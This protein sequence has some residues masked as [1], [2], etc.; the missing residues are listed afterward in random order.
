MN[1]V[2]DRVPLGARRRFPTTL[3]RLGV[4]N[5]VLAAALAGAGVGSYF[6]VA[7]TGT[8]PAPVRTATAERGVVTSSVSASGT[9]QAPTQVG[10]DFEASGRLTSVAVKAGQQVAKGQAL[11]TIDSTTAQQAVQQA[12]ASLA[13]AQAQYE[14]TVTGETAQQRRQDALSIAQA[15]QSLASAL[16]TVRMDGKSSAAAVAEAQRQLAVDQGQE[17]VDLYQQQKDQ[18]P[19]STADA[20]QAAVD[21]DKAQLAADTQQQQ[22]DQQTQYTYQGEQTTDN[23]QLT[24]DQAS[25]TAAQQAK[26][27]NGITTY[28]NAVN[29]DKADIANVEYLLNQI[30]K[31]LSTDGYDISLDNQ[32][33]TTDT[34]YLTALQSDTKTIRADEAKI[35]SD[36]Q[37]LQNAQVSA[38]TTASRDA[39]SVAAA[40]IGVKTARMSVAVKQAPPTA[41]ALAAAKAAVV[42]AQV[43]LSSAELTLSETT[44]RAPI[45][46]LV[47]SVNGVVGTTV[48][49][50]GSTPSATSSSSSGSS[51]SSSS[52]FVTLTDVRG[53][54]VSASFA[55]TDAAKLKVG[56]PATVT[57]DALPSKEFAAHVI[58]IAS[59]AS[60]S[61][62]NV[63]TYTVLFSL[64]QT[65]AQLKP[66]MTANVDVVVG[67]QDNVVHVPTA[68]INGSGS[69]ATVTVLRNGKQVT[70]PVVVGL[71]GDSSTA[72]L[73]GVKAGDQVV[74]PSVSIAASSSGTTGT[75]GAGTRGGGG[76]VFRFGGGFGG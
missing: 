15:K 20:A 22:N 48:A 21:A 5:A 61:S 70:V 7:G 69:G 63:V 13:S 68:A 72:I 54:L 76:A 26:D 17:K 43:A 62:S 11:G 60:T 35:G 36:R 2:T 47:A 41:A 38:S 58:S 30:Q 59:T 14:Q 1:V 46:G 29:A 49:G 33:V 74:L 71:Q 56:Q 51:G 16:A 31:Q 6:A 23:D 18:T 57:V 9:L 4:L 24:A 52:P 50:G 19:Y 66:G 28:T 27:N 12:E 65:A 40:Q 45:A 44:V 55:E 42:N 3:R 53:L 10:V 67:E 34:A 25:L 37:A 64:D 75:T 8:K 39:Q 32:K 73:S